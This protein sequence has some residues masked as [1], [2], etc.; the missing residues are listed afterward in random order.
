MSEHIV[1][2]KTYWVVWVALMILM[3]MTSALSR[4]PLGAWNTPIALA[5]AT[6]KALLVL[7]FFMHVKYE[8]YKITWVAVIGGF[9]WLFLLLGLTMTDYLSRGLSSMSGMTG[10]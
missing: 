5:I 3:V 4:I 6:V 8:S 7:L 2:K 10:R 1:P 9:F